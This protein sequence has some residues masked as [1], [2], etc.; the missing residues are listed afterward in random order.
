MCFER[1]L[2]LVALFDMALYV[3]VII[4]RGHGDR[5][6]VEPCSVLTCMKIADP[7]GP[8]GAMMP[9]RLTWSV[10]VSTSA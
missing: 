9:P 1:V 7:A 10:T 4:R 5:L 2:G 8:V 3:R 6:A